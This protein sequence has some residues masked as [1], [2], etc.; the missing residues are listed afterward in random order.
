MKP[1]RETRKVAGLVIGMRTMKTKR[2]GTIAI[3]TLMIEAGV[4]RR[5]CL[6]ICMINRVAA[7]YRSGVD[8]RKARLRRMSFQ[9][10]FACAPAPS[11]TSAKR[12]QIM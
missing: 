6:P 5:P 2:G 1:G 9:V 3:V 8:M 11:V 7:A 10:G 4:W 12:A